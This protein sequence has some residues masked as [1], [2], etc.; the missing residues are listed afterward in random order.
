MIIEIIYISRPISFKVLCMEWHTSGYQILVVTEIGY[1]GV[2]QMKVIH[3]L[4]AYFYLLKNVNNLKI[5]NN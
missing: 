5:T 2:Y 4:I 1:C 3:F